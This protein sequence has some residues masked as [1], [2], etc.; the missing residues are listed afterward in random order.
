M[1]LT[2]RAIELL[3][4]ATSALPGGGEARPGQVE[5][6]T[7]VA[8][9]IKNSGHLIVAAGTGTGK[10]LAY[11]APVVASGQRTVIA[12][13]TKALQDQLA[14]KELPHLQKVSSKP[15]EWAV[16]KGRNNYACRQRVNEAANDK[17]QALAGLKDSVEEEVERLVEWADT[18][19]TGDRAELD[20]EPS[21]AAWS[22]VSVTSRECPGR[23]KCPAGEVCL[24]EA[25]RTRAAEADVVVINTHLLGIDVLTK[26]A[27]L[28]DYQIL[29]VDEVHQLEDVITSTCGTSL[30]GG[31]FNA[32]ARLVAAILD[33]VEVTDALEDV[34]ALLSNAL[35][36]LVGQ[37]ISPSD[38]PDL[39]SALSI[40]RARV[41][42]T[43][44][45][46]K[47]IPKGDN[48]DVDARKERA[49]QAATALQGEL[50]GLDDVGDDDVVWVEQSFNNATLRVAPLD[51]GTVLKPDLWDDRIAILTSATIPDAMAAALG[52]DADSHTFLD[53][54]SPF[55]YANQGLLY[56]AQ[57][58]PEP[59]SPNYEEQVLPHLEE[60]IL[61]A[62]G[63]TLALFTS[64]RMMD[65]AADY[66]VPRMPWPV[67]TQRDL[68]KAALI[69]EFLENPESILLATMGFWHGID[70]PGASLSLVTID[71]LPFPRPDDP[72]LEARR[73]HAGRL[74]FRTV[75]LARATTLLAQGAGRL[76][77]T[78]TDEGVV[79]VL[80]GRLA[81]KKS[82][83]WD[84]IN[85]LPPFTRTSDPKVA[86][87]RLRQTREARGGEAAG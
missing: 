32:F 52:I 42:E 77:R 39:I 82:Y 51:V 19:A 2:E 26:G 7:A 27:V 84:F 76:I 36:P 78:S 58:L 50:V 72:L 56:C 46:L 35:E 33:S 43:V 41:D 22:A 85:A 71:R 59:R 15:F 48:A 8:E 80:D 40:G 62:G 1:G 21:P 24:A 34:G 86:M 20:F 17:Q 81:T 5:M 31:R 49:V 53:V 9:A 66:L 12:T 30:T 87:D 65:A 3:G 37:R 57:H 25:A 75:D 18:T 74:A 13:A 54:G 83:R 23:S 6:S 16:L 67:R 70:I 44:R 55:D 69:E 38:H 28:P 61:A 10:S 73:E 79:A 11:L 4:E 60:L 45:H 29:V 47:K 63:A 68:P 64:W 14:N